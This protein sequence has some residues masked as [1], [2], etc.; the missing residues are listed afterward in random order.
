[1][2]HPERNKIF[3]KDFT[4]YSGATLIVI[5]IICALPF[6]FTLHG[7]EA[8][9]FR[10]SGQIGDTIG[11]T[12]SPFVGIFAGLLTFLAF[13]VQYKANEQQ[14]SDIAIERFEN[15]LFQMM[16]LHEDITDNLRYTAP[17]SIPEVLANGRHVF[18]FIY[19]HRHWHWHVGLKTSISHDG[20]E[21]MTKDHSLWCLDHYFRHLYRTLKWVEE[22][23][24]RFFTINEKYK[25]AA[26]VRSMLSE[27]ELVLIFYNAL[28]K[29]NKKFK[30]LIEDYSI[31][32]NLR[33]DLLAR[34]EERSFYKQ[35]RQSDNVA[36][37]ESLANQVYT[38]KAIL[39]IV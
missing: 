12:M 26:L 17:D 8:L 21:A 18:E 2:E 29:E 37:P 32:D 5:A 35:L 19:L 36:C 38:Q 11:G 20:L 31:L 15:T 24:P 22:G 30:K 39:H 6:L 27:F 25:Y 10:Q 34:E 14:R 23:S 9:D 1:M 13:W 3:G 33:I 4:K 7:C 16:T 28:L